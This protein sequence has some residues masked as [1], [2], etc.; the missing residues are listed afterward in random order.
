MSQIHE[1]VTDT[2]DG[3]K[4]CDLQHNRDGVSQTHEVVTDEPV[5]KGRTKKWDNALKI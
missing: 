3:S 1:V 4:E 5:T 2:R